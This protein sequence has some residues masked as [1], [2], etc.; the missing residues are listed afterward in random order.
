MQPIH[1]PTSD[2]PLGPLIQID[3]VS[4]MTDEH[5]PLP[6]DVRSNPTRI[7][8]EGGIAPRLIVIFQGLIP[9]RVRNHGDTESSFRRLWEFCSDQ[10]QGEGAEYRVEWQLGRVCGAAPRIAAAAVASLE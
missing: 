6:A 7:R 3:N 2:T 9:L 5:D 4:D 8:L 1:A 10:R